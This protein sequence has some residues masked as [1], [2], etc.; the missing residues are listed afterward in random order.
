MLDDLADMQNAGDDPMLEQ[1]IQAT[2]QLKRQINDAI[3]HDA[4][5][6][7]NVPTMEDLSDS[8]CFSNCCLRKSSL[9]ILADKM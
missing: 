2:K 8:D 6:W 3:Q 7:G 5:N 1:L 4:I 9:Q